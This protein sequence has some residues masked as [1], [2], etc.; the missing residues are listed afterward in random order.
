M[1]NPG[2]SVT[3]RAGTLLL[4]AVFFASGLSA[5]LYQVIWQRVLALFSGADVFSVTIIVAAFMGGLGL[6]S[7]AGGHLADRVG[8]RG[9]LLLFAGAELAIGA[10]A[11]GS[12]AFYYDFLYAR[13][14]A[15]AESVPVLALVLFLSVLWPTF[16]MGLSLPLLSRGLTPVIDAAARIVGSLYGL[17]TLGAAVGAFVT[18]WILLR[19]FGFETCLQIGAV[20]NLACA[21]AALPF[22][23]GGA[24][25]APPSPPGTTERP[26]PPSGTRRGPSTRQWVLLFASSG[27]IALAFE[28]TWFRVLGVMLKSTAFTFGTLLCVYLSGIALGSLVATRRLRRSTADPTDR[29]LLLQTGVGLYAAFSLSVF[30]AGL[31]ED[32]ILGPFIRY[33]ASY[34]GLALDEALSLIG[35]EP[36]ALLAASTPQAAQ[37]RMFVLLYVLLPLVLIGPP[38]LMMG[39][40]FPYLQK[41]VQTDALVLGR[42]VGWLQAANI[43]GSL[44][45]SLLAGFVLLPRIGTADTLRLLT[46]ATGLYLLL[47][48][49]RRLRQRPIAGLV[50]AGAFGVALYSL[51]ADRTLWAH[52]H[53]TTAERIMVAEDAS[54]VSAIRP[55]GARFGVMGGGLGLSW[56]PYGGIHTF[57]GAFPALLHPDPERVAV[58]GLGSGDT[59][60][61]LGGRPET[62]RID[63]IEII[64]SQT[65][66]LEAFNERYPYPGVR[67]LLHDPRFRI[68]IGDGRTFLRR[69]DEGYDLIEADAL[70]PTSAYA[71]NLYSLEYFELLRSRLR[72]G[73]FAVTWAP[74]PRTQRTFVRVFP[75]VLLI[76]QL[77][78]GSETPIVFDPEIFW[79]RLEDPSVL[80]YYQRARIDIRRELKSFVGVYPFQFIGPEHDRSALKDVNQDLFARDE[81]LVPDG[82]DSLAPD[83]RPAVRQPLD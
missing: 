4:L 78:V 44:L 71:G 43:A 29:F 47:W 66:L 64:G 45:G 42:R 79:E 11:L 9:C 48:L 13:H 23:L 28:I 59:A 50:L 19:H 80:G 76:G 46:A 26:E 63:V 49:R 51:P 61:S 58:I 25:A 16:F 70:R 68:H 27:A 72:P 40:S 3:A 38:T 52:L 34:Q 21:A 15:L 67:R 65:D 53:G 14:G 62:E 31:G 7:L 82:Q 83:S 22:A 5:L 2:E 36:S 10:F 56:I 55:R 69:S 74:T 20:V 54:G 30:A 6:G 41:A 32:G 1:K 37:A 77:A 24:P 81:F 60:F 12:K 75:Y 73:G 18:T 17:N 57:L 8:R 33:F 39:M 35:R